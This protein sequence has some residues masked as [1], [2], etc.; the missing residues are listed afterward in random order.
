MA[1]LLGSDYCM[2]HIYLVV[3]VTWVTWVTVACYGMVSVE[4]RIGIGTVDDV[5][6]MSSEYIVVRTDTTELQQLE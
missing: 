4:M 1:E 6:Q 5:D 3:Q 2:V